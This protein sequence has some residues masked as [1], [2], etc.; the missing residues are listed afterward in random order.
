MNIQSLLTTA[1]WPLTF[2]ICALYLLH[3]LR[4]DIRPIVHGVIDSLGKQAGRNAIIW[5]MAL[6]Y[7]C[8]ASLQALAEVA[9]QL[10]WLYLAAAAKVLQP[11]IVA[12]IAYV[13]KAPSPAE[14]TA[15]QETK[16]PPVINV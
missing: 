14:P 2:L 11:G 13:N 9:T 16:E 10:Q 8:A 12:V 15:P 1:L 5:T 4:E 6:M 7:A 3:H